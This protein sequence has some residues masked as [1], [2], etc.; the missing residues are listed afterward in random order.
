MTIH[1]AGPVY[2]LVLVLLSVRIHTDKCVISGLLSVWIRT[3]VCASIYHTI[4]ALALTLTVILTLSL[5]LT[6]I[7]SYLT[8]KHQYPQP[9]NGPIYPPT[10][11]R[12]GYATN[13][14]LAVRTVG[15]FP[16][17]VLTVWQYGDL[18]VCALLIITFTVAGVAKHRTDRT[19]PK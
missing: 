13:E 18:S 7:S 8:N 14:Q 10:E 15:R 1:R 19:C 6:L 9:N 12:Q 3:A 5:N 11:W 16:L 17:A 4:H 2:S